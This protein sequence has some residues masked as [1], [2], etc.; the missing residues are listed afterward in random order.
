ML[1]LPKLAVIFGKAD[2]AMAIF[3][4]IFFV[5]NPIAAIAIG[6]FSGKNISFAWF[7]PLLLAVLFVL[8]SWIFFDMGE[9]DFIF[10]A[11]VYLL[12]GYISMLITLFVVRKR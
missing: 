8:E 9:K 4:L 12:L 10:Y 6:I 5:I 3:L 11:I 2:S 1:A 7:Q